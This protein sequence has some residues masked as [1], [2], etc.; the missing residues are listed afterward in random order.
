MLVIKAGIHEML[1]RIAKRE[2]SDQTVSSEAVCFEYVLF[3][4]AFLAFN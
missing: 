2:D 1:A 4:K 3:V